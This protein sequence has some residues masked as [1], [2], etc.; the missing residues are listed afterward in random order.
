M[1]PEVLVDVASPASQDQ[2]TYCVPLVLTKLLVP[3]VNP[4]ESN[5]VRPLELVTSDPVVLLES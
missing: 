4:A 3:I 5:A 1:E 2:A